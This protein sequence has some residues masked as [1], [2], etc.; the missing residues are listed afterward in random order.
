MIMSLFG[1][2]KR[3]I[4]GRAVGT[5]YGQYCRSVAMQFSIQSNTDMR[6]AFRHE[7]SKKP[8]HIHII[9]TTNFTAL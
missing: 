8:K 3:H 1:V 7:A 4:L 9:R 2:P 6:L 5:Y